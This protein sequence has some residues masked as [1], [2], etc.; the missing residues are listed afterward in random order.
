MTRK[1]SA[2]PQRSRALAMGI[3]T[4]ADMA[5]ATIPITVRREC[6]SKELVAKGAKL[7]ITTALKLFTR[8]RNQ[9]LLRRGRLALCV[10]N[11]GR[12]GHNQ[13]KENHLQY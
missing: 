8:V 11:T 9:I 1:P 4:A 12:V 6:P 5:D 3:Y 13:G 2:R 7:A 10:P